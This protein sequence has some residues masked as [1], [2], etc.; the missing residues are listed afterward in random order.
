[1]KITFRF[2]VALTLFTL[3]SCAETTLTISSKDQRQF[4]EF[5]DGSTAFL[6]KNSSIT[7][8]ETFEKRS[9]KQTGEVFYSVKKGA[10]PFVI[11]TEMGEVRVLGTE[12]NVKANKDGLEVEV[13]KGSVELRVHKLV[14]KIKKGQR[15]L[16]KEVDASFKIGKAEFQHKKWVRLLQK[17]LKKLEKEINKGTKKIGK[18]AKKI[19]ETLQSKFKSLKK[20]HE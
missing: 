10:V 20:K 1:M 17:D 13:E 11:T 2:L 14:K 19:G 7:Y 5:P 6:N 16:F 9:V 8:T 12:F 3:F 4:A 15:A 18:E